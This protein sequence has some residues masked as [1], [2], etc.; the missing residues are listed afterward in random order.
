[1]PPKSTDELQTLAPVAVVAEDT[2]SLVRERKVVLLIAAVQFVNVLD[3]VMVMPMGPDFALALGI[4]MSH[5]GAIGGAY[6]LAAAVA[7]LACTTFLDRFDRR[8]VLMWSMAGLA[9]GTVLGGFAWN[10]TSLLVARVVAGLFGGPATAIAMSIIA[11]TVPTQRRGRA[12]GTVMGSFSIASVVGI[13]AG[14][15]LATA[16][17]W[18]A[19]FF[20]IGALCVVVTLLSR[21]LLPEL[22]DHMAQALARPLQFRDAAT[23]LARREFWLCYMMAIA[24][25]MSAFL[26]IPNLSAYSQFNLGLPRDQLGSL[27][28]YGG[29]ASFASMWLTGRA[30]DRFGSLGVTLFATALFFGVLWVG[31]WNW[32]GAISVIAVF[33]PY[34]VA[35]SSRNVAFNAT[36]SKVAQPHERARFMSAMSAVQHLAA[37]AGSIT[38]GLLLV[39]LPDHSLQGMAAL[40]VVAFGFAATLPLWLG[41]LERRLRAQA[42]V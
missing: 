11:D 24:A 22:R 23:I 3:F 32:T 18:R 28:L 19:P 26:L 6:T 12:M 2:A 40:A 15:E 1:M 9:L 21:L 14:L 36:V 16:G 7:G 41:L 13:P 30:V 31:F 37:A 5:L 34:F 33:V 42:V 4:D 39:E 35:N 20:A 10:L 25:A 8:T 17:G 29:L 27:Y 38:P